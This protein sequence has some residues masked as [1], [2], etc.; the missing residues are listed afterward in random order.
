M[1]SILTKDNNSLGNDETQNKP[2][3]LDLISAAIAGK[4]T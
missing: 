3:N 4:W 2:I 1:I